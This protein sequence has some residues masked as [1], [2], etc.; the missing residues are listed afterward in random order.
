M[1][2]VFHQRRVWR[3]HF[4]S[5][6]YLDRKRANLEWEEKCQEQLLK[7]ILPTA[8]VTQLKSGSRFVCD[9][10]EE[11]TGTF[12]FGFFFVFVFGFCLVLSPVGVAWLLWI[13]AG[14]G[15]G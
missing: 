11:V 13:L 1:P 9:R 3:K 6:K 5:L 14:G 2:L 4:L 8:V 15:V 10:R 12:G 7:N